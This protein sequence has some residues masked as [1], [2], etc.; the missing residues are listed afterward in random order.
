M[1][2]VSLKIF[3]AK[4]IK[5]LLVILGAL[6]FFQFPVLMQQ[7]Q[8][9]LVGHVNELKWQ[10]GAIHQSALMSGK[11]VDE[12]IKKFT[13][14]P[15]QDFSNQGKLMRRVQTRFDKLMTALA[16]LQNSSIFT[17][18]F[19]FFLYIEGDIFNSTIKSFEPGVTF[20]TE[21]LL[22]AILGMLIG[23]ILFACFK[24]IKMPLFIKMK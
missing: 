14:H 8:H 15:D 11:T 12:Y 20:S 3:A 10:V 7:Y 2:G 5:G 19:I 16:K 13:D 23:Y 4:L 21:G 22:Y 9:Q 1:R 18:P 17:R 24:K 6:F